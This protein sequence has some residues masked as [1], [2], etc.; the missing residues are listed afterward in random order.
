MSVVSGNVDVGGTVA[1]HESLKTQVDDKTA[2][3][4]TDQ[5]VNSFATIVIASDARMVR[6]LFF[7]LSLHCRLFWYAKKLMA[8]QL[9]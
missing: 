2:C 4:K 8:I 6:F 3:S 7:F 5:A 9:L 1:K